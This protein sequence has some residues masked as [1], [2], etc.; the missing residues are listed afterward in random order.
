MSINYKLKFL[1]TSPALT[2]MTCGVKEI[3]GQPAHCQNI[4]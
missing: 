4:D 1:F 2:V 3:P